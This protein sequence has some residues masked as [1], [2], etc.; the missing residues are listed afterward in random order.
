MPKT[1]KRLRKAAHLD[2]EAVCRIA[3]IQERQIE[4]LQRENAALQAIVIGVANLK[5]DVVDSR[6]G[7]VARRPLFLMEN[8]A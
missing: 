2:P 8:S 5:I 1:A 7:E 4:A 6:T 3:A